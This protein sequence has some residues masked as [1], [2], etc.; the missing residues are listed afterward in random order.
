MRL[1]GCRFFFPFFGVGTQGLSPRYCSQFPEEDMGVP[2]VTGALRKGANVCGTAQSPPPR[3]T[4]TPQEG[5]EGATLRFYLLLN[6]PYLSSF[7]L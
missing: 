5:R 6:Q 4:H 7:A 1:V 3:P 2:L